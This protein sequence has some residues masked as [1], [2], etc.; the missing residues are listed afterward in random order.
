MTDK[1]NCN[2]VIAVDQGGG[3]S[4]ASFT[5]NKAPTLATTHDGAPAV[6]YGI[7][8]AAFNQGQNAQGKPAISKEQGPALTAR[9]AGGWRNP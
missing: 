2:A 6:A 1:G 8:R 9:G 4:G 7:D 5:E 3:K